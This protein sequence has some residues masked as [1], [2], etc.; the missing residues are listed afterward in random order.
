MEKYLFVNYDEDG[1][2]IDEKYIE[3]V[4]NKYGF[5][6]PSVLKD[7]YLQHNGCE[8]YEARFEKLGLEFCVVFFYNLLYGKITVEKILDSNKNDEYIPKTFVPVARDEDGNDY[9]W[10]S[11]SR[12]VYYL[13]LTNIEHPAELFDSVDEF[14][15]T[16]NS[17]FKS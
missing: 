8:M 10:D 6:F 2:Q 16:L 1:Y 9:Y 5:S 7:Y 4:E 17:S 14:F 3:E 15:Q 11:E 12:K 13:A